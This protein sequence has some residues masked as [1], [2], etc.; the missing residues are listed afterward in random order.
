MYDI[1]KESPTVKRQ[2]LGAGLPFKTL[3][4]EFSD[5][6]PVLEDK[7]V[8]PLKKVQGWVDMV[9]EGKVVKSLGSPFCGV[10]L[11]LQGKPGHGKTTIAS[12]ALQRLIRGI[13]GDVLGTPGR[14]PKRVG[15]FTDYPKLLRVQKSQFGEDYDEAVQAK[16]D[17]IYGDSDILNN[18]PVFVLDDIGKEYRTSSGWSENQFDALL[19]SRF[20]AGL[21]TIVTTNVPIEEWD[22]YGASMASFAHEAFI[23]LTIVAPG[24]D[25]RL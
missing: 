19:R 23:P 14:L 25:R 5:L 24:G 6:G 4:M 13:S 9:L 18:V 10:G 12:T 17:G 15:A 3:G 21:P 11:M 1:S 16:L 22:I 2:L 8:D 20:N 7:G